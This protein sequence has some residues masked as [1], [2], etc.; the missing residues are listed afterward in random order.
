MPETRNPPLMPSGGFY[1]VAELRNASVLLDRDAITQNRIVI[2]FL[3]MIFSENRF[4]LF[5]IMLQE[6]SLR[7]AKQRS[8][9]DFLFG[10]LDCFASLSMTKA[11]S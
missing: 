9:P 11:G 8:N 7:G 3:S 6:A 4:P 10:P 1:L 5:R 2:S